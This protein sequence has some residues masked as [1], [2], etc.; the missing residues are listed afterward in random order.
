MSGSIKAAA[1]NILRYGEQGVEGIPWL[2]CFR[3][4]GPL[5]AVSAP[6]VF[7]KGVQKRGI[8]SNAQKAL[9]KSGHYVPL[10]FA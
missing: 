7:V 5:R 6:E 10:P 4:V 3:A 8:T 9:Y 1:L 2:R